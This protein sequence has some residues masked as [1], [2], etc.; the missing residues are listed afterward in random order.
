MCTKKVLFVYKKSLKST[1]PRTINVLFVYQKSS[2]FPEGLNPRGIQRA[3]ISYL[4]VFIYF[5][6]IERIVMCIKVC[7]KSHRIKYDLRSLLASGSS[8]G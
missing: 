4:L 1:Y 3:A 8:F 2:A 7:R 5:S 6:L